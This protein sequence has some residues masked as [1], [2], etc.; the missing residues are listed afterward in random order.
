[1]NTEPDIK[2]ATSDA[3]NNIQFADVLNIEDIQRLQDLFSDASEIG[4]ASCRERV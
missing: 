3:I 2:N 4:R 1:M